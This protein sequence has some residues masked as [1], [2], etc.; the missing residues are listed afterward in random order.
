[1]IRH[2][3]VLRVLPALL[4]APLLLTACG[5]ERADEAR[6]AGSG[7][8]SAADAAPSAELAARAR[9]LGVAPELV[10]V[11]GSPGYTLAQ[12]SVGVYGADGFSAVYVSA[13]GGRLSLF[14]DRASADAGTCAKGARKWTTCERDGEAWYRAGAQRHEYARPEDDHVVR[15][16][17]D[18]GAVPRD[19][20]RAAATA[21]HR[22]DAA[23]AEALLPPAG[24]EATASPVERGD[25]PPVGDGAPDNNVDAGG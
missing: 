5:T 16:A 24:P 11:T 6:R 2:V 4:L 3:R 15:I 1:M 12:Q 7:S 17:A 19:V 10:Y 25:L 8:G 20:L 9:A 21:A 23:E 14:V 18:R 13:Q 22:P